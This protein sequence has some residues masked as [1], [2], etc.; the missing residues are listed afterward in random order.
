MRQTKEEPQYNVELTAFQKDAVRTALFIMSEFQGVM[1]ADATG[2]WQD[3][4]GNGDSAP[5]DTKREQEGS[6]GCAIAGT[7]LHVGQK[8]EGGRPERS[9]AGNN[10]VSRERK[11]PLRD[12]MSTRILTLYW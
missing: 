8:T 12:G 10:G 7:S 5:K 6:A 2:P 9:Q 1:I 11:T 4:H 3:Q